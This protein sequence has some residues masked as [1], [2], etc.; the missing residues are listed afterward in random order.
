MIRRW[1]ALPA[2]LFLWAASALP[3][4]ARSGP[5]SEDFRPLPRSLAE[6]EGA[7]AGPIFEPLEDLEF[8]G[9]SAEPEPFRWPGQEPSKQEEPKKDASEPP[10]GPRIFPPPH[11]SVGDFADTHF[12]ALAWRA[13]VWEDYLLSPE[14]LIPVGLALGAVIIHP[15]DKQIQQKWFGVNGGKQ[16]YSTVS[17]DILI[18]TAIGTGLLLPGEGRNW[19]D[20][21]WSMGESYGS[22][23]L[24]VYVLKTTVK[25]PRPGQTPGTVNGTQSFP[26]GHSSSAFG[27]AVLIQRNSGWLAGVPAYGL[28]AFTAFERVEAGRHWPSDV[29]AGGAV[30]A[31]SS[32]IFDSLHWGSGEGRGIA[33]VLSHVQVDFFDR[34]HGVEAGFAF[35]F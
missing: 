23:A 6:D 5:D 3:A 32:G 30:G 25:R 28:A 34:L 4:S 33:R 13:F 18:G 20:N 9:R 7:D 27:S 17:N 21:A 1:A 31:M 22:A 10:E 16:T 26:S 24:T 11:H 15:W 2:V 29:F 14:V 12:S 35:G 8:A 19:W